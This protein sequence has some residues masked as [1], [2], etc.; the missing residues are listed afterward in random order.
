[1]QAIAH[2]VSWLPQFLVLFVLGLTVAEIDSMGF[3]IR[4]CVQISAGKS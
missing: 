4:I 3:V 2:V 1:M